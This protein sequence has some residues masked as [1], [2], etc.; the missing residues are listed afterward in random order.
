MKKTS[1]ADIFLWIGLGFILSEVIYPDGVDVAYRMQRGLG[2][3][4]I[5]VVVY[6]I[7]RFVLEKPA[8]AEKEDKAKDS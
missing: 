2:I 1:R 8:P 7:T 5:F 3:L 6:V 4:I